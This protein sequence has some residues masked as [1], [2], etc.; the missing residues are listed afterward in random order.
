MDMS[1]VKEGIVHVRIAGMKWLNEYQRMIHLRI[2]D[3][4][5]S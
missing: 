5:T 1:A 2:E 4:D 3:N